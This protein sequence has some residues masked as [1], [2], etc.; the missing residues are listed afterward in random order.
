MYDTQDMVDKLQREEWT[1][2]QVRRLYR[3]YTSE[4]CC[5]HG[6]SWILHYICV[7]QELWSKL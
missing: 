3:R 1:R 6:T 5:L 4:K 7:L 2:Q